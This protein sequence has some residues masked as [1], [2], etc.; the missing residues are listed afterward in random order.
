[1]NLTDWL[2]KAFIILTAQF[3]KQIVKYK[4]RHFIFNICLFPII[5]NRANN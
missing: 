5:S 4:N 3:N 2:K 1:M